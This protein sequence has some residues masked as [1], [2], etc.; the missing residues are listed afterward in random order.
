[1]PQQI[2]D[3]GFAT[4]ISYGEDATQ[5]VRLPIDA[6]EH[7]PFRL[8]YHPQRWGFFYDETSKSGDWL[9]QLSAMPISPG[10]GN[11]DKDGG[12][13]FAV[14][15]KMAEGWMV[16]DP[17]VLPGKPYIV[18]FDAMNGVAWTTAWTKMKRVGSRHIT[19]VDEAGYREWLR[20]LVAVGAVPA[21]DPDILGLKRS[22]IE[23]EYRRDF[24]DSAQD[25]KARMRA[26]ISKAMLDAIDAL[27]AKPQDAG[28]YAQQKAAK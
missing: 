27:T 4:P 2:V 18:G 15:I 19:N 5:R 22:H 16:L 23:A 14:A 13:N 1:M 25:L 7:P 6:Q 11:V 26:E 3:S 20:E 28:Q 17:N 8:C 21:A 10:V 24:G 9:P 12:I